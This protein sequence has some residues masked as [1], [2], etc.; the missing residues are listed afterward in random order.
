MLGMLKVLVVSIPAP[1]HLNPMLPLVRALVGGGD[2]VVIAA[3]AEMAGTATGTGAEF[4]PVGHG[5]AVWFERLA[6]RTRGAPGDGLAAERINHYFLPRVF[7]EIGTDDMIDDVVSAGEALRPDLVLFESYA[8]AGPLAGELLGVPT[9]NHLLGPLLPHEV[10]ELANDA[11]SPLWRSF[12]R[13]TPGYAGVYRD[14]TI[15]ICPPSLEVLGVPDGATQLLRPAPPPERVLPEQNGG[16]AAPLVYVTLGTFFGNAEIF[17]T[18]LS[19]LA[20]QPV[21]VV[22]TVGADRDPGEIGPV[23]PNARVERFIPQAELLPDCSAVVHHGGAGTTF[24]SLAHGLPQVVVPQGADNFI[25][26]AMLERAG[27]AR[28]L[29]PDQVTPDQVGHA[30]RSVLEDASYRAAAGDIAD[31]LVGM[32]GP[33]QVADALRDRYRK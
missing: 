4:H 8:M 24:G 10:W 25:H 21:E 22:V 7:G 13:Y 31:E 12:G 23:P 30:V 29:L 18:I 33:E 20:D 9:V 5:E 11:V 26:G 16:A 6:A 3:A 17:A 32:P 1:G 19:G 14:L 2:R 28:V 27:V 15:S